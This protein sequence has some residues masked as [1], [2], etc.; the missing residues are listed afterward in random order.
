MEFFIF[1]VGGT[2]S[3]K[4]YFNVTISSISFIFY[5]TKL[6]DLLTTQAFGVTRL[7]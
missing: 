5:F 2:V 1:Q 4:R 3:L 6:L 7:Q